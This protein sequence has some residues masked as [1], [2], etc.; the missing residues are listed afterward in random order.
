MKFKNRQHEIDIYFFFSGSTGKT[1]KRKPSETEPAVKPRIFKENVENKQT[2]RKTLNNRYSNKKKVLEE[3]NN[4]KLRE[5]EVRVEDCLQANSALSLLCRQ[6][7][8]E[9][10]DR[11]PNSNPSDSASV[12]EE[13]EAIQT[14]TVNE[15]ITVEDTNGINISSGDSSVGLVSVV[16]DKNNDVNLE[17]ENVQCVQ[18]PIPSEEVVKEGG[19]NIIVNN[20]TCGSSEEDC[21]IVAETTKAPIDTPQGKAADQEPNCSIRGEH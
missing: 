10:T 1:R 17:S 18:S 4:S 12:V 19:D 21:V 20:S 14:D 7:L 16:N 9:H 13:E 15:V 11:S 5:I 2:R 6:K 3:A 8:E